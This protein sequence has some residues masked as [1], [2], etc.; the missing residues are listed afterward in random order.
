MLMLFES[1]DAGGSGKNEQK[2]NEVRQACRERDVPP[3]TACN[4]E[5]KRHK[6]PYEKEELILPH[7]HMVT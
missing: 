2:N 3:C 7:L 6:Q 4:A 5:T 1:K